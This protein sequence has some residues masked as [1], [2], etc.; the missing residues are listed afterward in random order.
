MALNRA[1]SILQGRGY[2]ILLATL[3]LLTVLDPLLAEL[4]LHKVVFDISFCVVLAAT[5]Y[6]VGDRRAPFWTALVLGIPAAAFTWLAYGFH[7]TS[8]AG[9][10]VIVA[11]YFLY[12]L[13]LGLMAGLILRDV[14]RGKRVTGNNICGAICVYFFVG[15]AWGMLYALADQLEP[16]SLAVAT[17]LRTTFAGDARTTEHISISIYIYYSFVTLSTLGYGDVSPVTPAVCTFAWLEAVMGQLYIAVL[18]ARLVGMH[19]AQSEKSC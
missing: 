8:T 16:G 5:V 7:P 4:Q 3:L 9:G 1:R 14:F 15:V 10:V 17:E 13:F 18:V 6:A 11:R 2:Y 12:V 19:I